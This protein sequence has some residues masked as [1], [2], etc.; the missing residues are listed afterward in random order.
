MI[1]NNLHKKIYHINIFKKLKIYSFCIF[2]INVFYQKYPQFLDKHAID[3]YAVAF[4]IDGKGDLLINQNSF[5][6]EKGSLILIF[7][8]IEYFLKPGNVKGFIIFFCQDFYT[9]EF[10]LTRLLKVFAPSVFSD[11]RLFTINIEHDKH[12]IEFDRIFTLM[13]NEYSANQMISSL[14]VI[15]SYMN[16]LFLKVIDLKYH[17]SD[18]TGDLNNNIFLQFSRL[19]ET[20]IFLHHDVEFY[21]ES[22]NISTARLNTIL[23]SNLNLS[24]KRVI[25][26]KLMSEARKLL[27]SSDL[28]SSEIAYKL[29]FYDNS[30]F[31]KVFL[32]YHK[33]TPGKFRTIHKKYH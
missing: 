1:N 8:N 27:M 31:T 11:K 32:K 13:F 12:F 2:D 7:P 28:S 15:R 3:F 23:K 9:E 5:P 18:F 19:L 17:N 29:N 21:A 26:N 25:Q 24:A 14:S 22:L 16:I 4:I 33:I 30:Y 10:T 6:V 20:N